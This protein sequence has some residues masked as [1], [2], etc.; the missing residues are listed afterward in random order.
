M[1]S[2]DFPLRL[3]GHELTY[4]FD[5]PCGLDIPLRLAGSK[6]DVRRAETVGGVSTACRSGKWDDDRTREGMSTRRVR[7]GGRME[8]P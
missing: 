8:P 1:R 6:P 7:V 4:R 2:V 5:W 3:A